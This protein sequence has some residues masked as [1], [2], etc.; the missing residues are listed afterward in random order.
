[1]GKC[2]GQRKEEMQRS[3][4]AMGREGPF[5]STTSKLSLALTKLNIFFFL[6][7]L[8]TLYVKTRA[9]LKESFLACYKD[10]LGRYEK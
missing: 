9:L 8:V 2:M 4:G 1:M 6:Y 5:S 10:S 3:V 7:F